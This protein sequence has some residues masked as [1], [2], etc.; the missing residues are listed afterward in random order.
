MDY[1][2]LQ[3][4]RIRA[5]RRQ[6]EIAAAIGIAPCRLSEIETGRRELSPELLAKILKALDYGNQ[7]NI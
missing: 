5:G 6:Y 1:K 7:T 2:E 3:L 4:I